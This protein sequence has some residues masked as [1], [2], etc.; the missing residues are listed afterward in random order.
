[1]ITNAKIIISLNI[2]IGALCAVAALYYVFWSNSLAAAEYRIAA[3]RR[4]LTELT[5]QNGMMLAEKASAEDVSAVVRFAQGKGMIET[6][7]STYIF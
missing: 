6:V 2:F 1:M 7:S 5:D 3:L 4:E